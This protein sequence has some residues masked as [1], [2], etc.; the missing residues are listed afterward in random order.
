[1]DDNYFI[2]IYNPC[3]GI[4]YVVVYDY[5][6]KLCSDGLSYLKL[7]HKNVAQET[8]NF[9]LCHIFRYFSPNSISLAVSYIS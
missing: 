6:P 8:V 3:L 2:K 7:T 4:L 1:M 5:P 9:Y